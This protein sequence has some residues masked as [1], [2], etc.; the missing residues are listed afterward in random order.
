M[1]SKEY[2]NYMQRKELILNKFDLLN[3]DDIIIETL[4]DM[5]IIINSTSVIEIIKKVL[6][7]IEMYGEIKTIDILNKNDEHLYKD[8][9]K[10]NLTKSLLSSNFPY[11]NIESNSFKQFIVCCAYKVR[12]NMCKDLQYTKKVKTIDINQKEK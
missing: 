3:I 6:F 9:N 8:I 10:K 1:R 12:N 7:D 11:K 4:N 2:N 5:G